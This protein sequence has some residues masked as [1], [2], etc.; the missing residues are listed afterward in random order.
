MASIGKDSNGRKRILFVAPDGSRKTLRLG[1]VSERTA[2]RVKEYVEDLVAVQQHGGRPADKTQE[3]LANMKDTAHDRV[4]RAGLDKPRG[5]IR[6]AIPGFIAS[7]VE[8]RADCKQNTR[9]NW[10]QVRQWLVKCFGEDRDIRTIGAAEAEDF[11]VFMVKAGL[12]E[13]TIR[14]HV[15]RCRQLFKGAIRRGMI[16]GDNPFEGMQATVRADKERQFFVTRAIADRVLDQC[17]DNQWKLMFV[18]SRYGGIRTPSETLALKWVDID[19]EHNRIRVPSCKTEHIEGHECRYIP[20]FP[21]IR[22]HLQAVFDEAEE[23][24]EYVITRYRSQLVNLRTQ[25]AKIIKRAGL[26]PWPKPWHNMR[27]TRQTELAEKYPI[28]VVCAW[29]G[30]SRAVAQEHY[31]QVTDAHFTQAVAEAGGAAQNPAQYRAEPGGNG[32]EGDCENSNVSAVSET[33]G[34]MFIPPTGFE[35][36]LPP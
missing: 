4:A 7:Y 2:T 11:R 36:V 10:T 17:P 14:R 34:A 29:L 24:S 16:W 25:M 33:Y 22:P 8:G 32:V 18:L 15:G 1:K 23:G 27:S 13:N 12:S 26:V 21:E 35:P 6:V 3:W 9:E 20:L 31:L 5:D 30:N 28:H 19:W